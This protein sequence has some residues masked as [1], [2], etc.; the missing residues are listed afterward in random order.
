[1]NAETRLCHT[2]AADDRGHMITSA[3]ANAVAPQVRDAREHETK[4]VYKSTGLTVYVL[5][6]AGVL[7]AAAL[8]ADASFGFWPFRV[9]EKG[10]VSKK[11]RGLAFFGTDNKVC[12]AWLA[13]ALQQL[14][15]EGQSKV[16]GY[17]EAVSE[18]IV[19]EMKMAPR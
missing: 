7:I 14:R 4:S 3:T 12:L 11:N 1:M 19:F 13:G 18:E 8:V 9:S 5:A 6:V 15:P 17:L 16:V 2:N 10:A